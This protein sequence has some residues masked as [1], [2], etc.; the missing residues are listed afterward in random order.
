MIIDHRKHRASPLRSGEELPL[1]NWSA[2]EEEMF[3]YEAQI[4]S[5]CLG[6]DECFWTE[7]FL[8]ETY[9]GSEEFI[10][11]YFNHQDPDSHMDPP[12]GNIIRMNEPRFDPRAYWLWKVERRILQATKEFAALINTFDARM[13]DYVS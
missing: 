12:L 2:D 11:T 4:S 1:S 7:Y 10:P 5:L 9:F 3:F 6:P 13:Q 8:V